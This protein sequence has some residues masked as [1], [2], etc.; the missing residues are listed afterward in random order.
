MDRGKQGAKRSIVTDANGIALGVAVAGANRNDFKLARE[1]LES[2]P[3]ERPTPTAE[4]PQGMCLDK[5][6]D[7]KEI[8]AL[9][10]EFGF[11]PHVRRRG[12]PAQP[13]E[14]KPGAKPRRWVVE[15]KHSWMNRSRDILIRWCKKAENYLGLLHLTL[16]VVTWR[17]YAY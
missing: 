5:D 2:I 11:T 4:S 6:C 16:G 1:T 8:G 3:I 9:L 7:K 12:E 17:K 13:L 10:E 15:R 14:P